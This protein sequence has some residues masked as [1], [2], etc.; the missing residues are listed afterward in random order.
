MPRHSTPMKKLFLSIALFVFTSAKVGGTISTFSL[1][2]YRDRALRF[3]QPSPASSL[4]DWLQK[5]GV[6]FCSSAPNHGFC[7]KLT[8]LRSPKTGEDIDLG[9]LHILKNVNCPEPSGG[10]REAGNDVQVSY[11]MALHN[12]DLMAAQAIL[13]LFRTAREADSCEF[14]VVDDGSNE[15]PVNVLAV[16]GKLQHFFGVK[17]LF[18]KN[19]KAMGFGKANDIGIKAANGRFIA[20]IN[21]DVYV[22][23]GWLAALLASFKT[24]FDVGI[25]GPLFLGKEALVTEAGGI[26]FHDGNAAN[27][28]RQSTTTLDLMYA[29]KVDYISAACV[30]IER[31]LYQLVS[32]FDPSFG[33]GY[34]EDTD[35]AFAVRQLG[36]GILY[37]PA[38]VVYHQEG[39]TLGT[40]ASPVKQALMQRN[41]ARFKKKWQQQLLSA[42]V[43]LVNS[44]Q[45][46]S[47]QRYTGHVLWVDDIVP[48]PDRD[49]GSIRTLCTLQLLLRAGF[50]VSYQPS[51][52][53]E[54][55]YLWQARSLGLSVLPVSLA[56]SWALRT[57]DGLCR[58]QAIVIARRYV[59]KGAY[60]MVKQS[61][62]GVPVVY[63]T[64][65]LHFL[66][67]SRDKITKTSPETDVS[68]A[69]V[70]HWLDSSPEAVFERQQ[71][72]EE[73]RYVKLSNVT[74]VV[75]TTEVNVL[76]HYLPTAS[77]VVVSNIHVP[78]GSTVPCSVRKG[79]LFVG[80]LNHP[81][82]NQAIRYFV[83][84]VLPLIRRQLAPSSVKDFVFHIV[85]S[86]ADTQVRELLKDN[87]DGV[88][89]HGHMSNTMLAT[90]YSHIRVAVAPLLSGA[91]VKGKV[92]Q[93][94]SYGVP[95][96]ATNTAVEGMGV[97]NGTD[98]LVASDAA[99]F[100][101]AVVSLHNSCELWDNLAK[102]GA[103][104]ILR[105]FSPSLAWQRLKLA[106]NVAGA[107]VAMLQ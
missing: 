76:Q 88:V 1:Q 106:F 52:D 11:I 42:H 96:V 78:H 68:A 44:L 71:R 94:M 37:Q 74:M 10:Q 83:E 54:A 21:T 99:Q 39:N 26:V 63:D 82:N 20:L 95:V 17:V 92:N 15:D 104:N 22:P 28:G 29:R 56:H 60:E 36:Y 31:R 64:V 69:N 3:P 16:L 75:S 103:Q 2:S 25:V 4:N 7:T 89:F 93:A 72:D 30:L 51:V 24:N 33:Q 6:G 53:R 32:G 45:G 97:V 14:I 65:D 61:C 66:R 55:S 43:K 38:S 27:Y 49:S 47:Y 85:G 46:P 8:C 77:V 90:L 48:E 13:E 57:S 105:N 58:Y 18:L 100:A 9:H 5:H 50:R 12:N 107:P 102:G 35:L 86:N 40:D 80:N 19:M 79:A 98:C 67:E 41:H 87:P 62:P 70:L 34:F 23:N 84:Q 91:G 59:F 81:P 101:S 73:L